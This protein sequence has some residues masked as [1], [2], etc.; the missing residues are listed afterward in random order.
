MLRTKVAQ[1]TP[2]NIAHRRSQSR[3]DRRYQRRP[4]LISDQ[5]T[6]S[7]RRPARPAISH[8]GQTAHHDRPLRRAEHGPMTDGSMSVPIDRSIHSVGAAAI[9]S[10]PHRSRR[11]RRHARHQYTL[12]MTPPS[13]GRGVAGEWAPRRRAHIAGSCIPERG[14]DEFRGSDRRRRSSTAR[15][16]AAPIVVGVVIEGGRGT[17]RGEGTSADTHWSNRPD[18]GHKPTARRPVEATRVR[19]RAN[20]SPDLGEPD[21]EVSHKPA[22]RSWTNW[23]RRS[24]KPEFEVGQTAV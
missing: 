20:R 2:S 4:I 12:A 24:G 23:H 9:P 3:P 7:P 13:L 5:Y 11:R 16:R 19:S 10:A 22:G 8:R 18:G 1:I 14:A 15:W 6:T 17:G 21:S